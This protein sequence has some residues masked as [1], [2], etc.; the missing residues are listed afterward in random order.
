MKTQKLLGRILPFIPLLIGTVIVIVQMN[1]GE[2]DTRLS[3][4]LMFVLIISCLISWL[5]SAL[6]LLLYKESLF[7]YY[8]VVFISLS[9]VY[10]FP[11]IFLSLFVPWT[12]LFTVII[13]IAGL[14]L[15][16]RHKT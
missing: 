4:T 6:G 5:F 13:F 7:D 8:K 14:F 12:L 15:I 10:I 11:A 1:S 9:I 3:L 2:R 16:R